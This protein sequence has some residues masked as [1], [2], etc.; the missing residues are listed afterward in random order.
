MGL[1]G[2]NGT[3]NPGVPGVLP[4][5]LRPCLAVAQPTQG[6]AAR[7]WIFPAPKQAVAELQEPGPWAGPAPQLRLH[8]QHQGLGRGGGVGVHA[9]SPGWDSM[10]SPV[11]PDPSPTSPA[12]RTLAPAKSPYTQPVPWHS[13]PEP[14]SDHPAPIPGPGNPHLQA[15]QPAACSSIT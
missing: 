11:S 2:A 5:P 3:P 1:W 9:T 14:G 10:S 13:V 7:E 4:L 8:H 12:A 6:P 15:V